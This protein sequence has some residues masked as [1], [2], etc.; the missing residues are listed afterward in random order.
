MR[1]MFLEIISSS[2]NPASPD[3]IYFSIGSVIATLALILAFAQLLRPITQFRISTGRFG[4][5]TA[6][7][8]F[9]LA[10][11]FVF[12][13][14]ILPFIHGES[15]WFL[16][17]PI[18]WEILAGLFF[19]MAFSLIFWK[20]YRPIKFSKSNYKI[21]QEKCITFIARGHEDDLRELA[22]E[23]FHSIKEIIKACKRYD[24]SKARREKEKGNKYEISE[25]TR[26][27][28]GLLGIW[29][30]EKFCRIIVC[31]TPQTAIEIFSQIKKQNL[32]HSGGHALVKQ[33]INQAFLNHSSIL[34]REVEYY[35]L[36]LLKEFTNEAFGDSIFVES[37]FRPLD[38][39]SPWFDE[40][41]EPWKTKKL[42]EVIYIATEA[43]IKSNWGGNNTGLYCGL[44]ALNGI[45]S[46][47]AMVLEKLSVDEDYNS[48]AYK[49]FY[50]I[51]HGFIKIL[52]V[53]KENED[54]IY[55]CEIDEKNYDTFKDYSLYG[56]F[57][58]AIFNFLKELSTI[59][60]HD[61]LVRMTAI[62]L[63]MDIY[64]LPDEW[65]TKSIKAIQKRLNIHLLKKVRENLEEL[66]YPAL[67]RLL[68]NII[69]VQK[70]SLK[71][72]SKGRVKFE[73]EFFKLIKELYESAY[74]KD[75]KKAKDMLPDKVKY[76]KTKGQLIY[77]Y[78]GGSKGIFDL[79][80]D[81]PKCFFSWGE[82]K[83]SIFLS[84][85]PAILIK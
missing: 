71:T 34:Y 14:A 6:M 37:Q 3:R 36:G 16:G 73:T 58:E 52:K 33:L 53:I 28:L 75:V 78:T 40:N 79:R 57:S 45:A 22:D 12:L 4:K 54:K 80:E 68:L 41:L 29:S 82:L 38:A 67:T 30:D 47:Q 59:H 63:W 1:K 39:W 85:N 18:F 76:N 21:Y 62:S 74:K 60:S 83:V 43:N 9:L 24:H 61:E 70:P 35:G 20:I 66:Y 56:V 32:Y 46:K 77:T 15:I 50:E 8:L 72:E 19:L 13:A 27:A 44:K 11:L 25:H 31:H 51:E 10:I 48:Y 7:I 69:G 64:P 26:F 42:E 55:D 2:Y 23:I 65:E 81:T 49:N 5:K 84:T 17:Y